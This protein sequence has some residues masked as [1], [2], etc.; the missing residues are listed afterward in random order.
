MSEVVCPVCGTRLKWKRYP[1]REISNGVFVTD[2]VIVYKEVV[3]HK[4]GWSDWSWK[5]E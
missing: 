4:C 2:K 3:C 1:F 5:R